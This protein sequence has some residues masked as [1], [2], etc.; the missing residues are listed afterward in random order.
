MTLEMI[1]DQTEMRMWY[2]FFFVIIITLIISQS[3]DTVPRIS[4]LV[5]PV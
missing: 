4:Q 2:E 3:Q 5:V 1:L